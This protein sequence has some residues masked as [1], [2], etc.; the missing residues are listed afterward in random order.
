[1]DIERKIQVETDGVDSDR[2]ADN[3]RRCTEQDWIRD[4]YAVSEMFDGNENAWS[5]LAR[6]ERLAEACY[7]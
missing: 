2:E 1:M 3:R 6:H 7:E 5:S 4:C